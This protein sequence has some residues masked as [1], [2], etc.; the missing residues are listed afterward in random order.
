M[1]PG[2]YDMKNLPGRDMM[3]KISVT[4][5]TIL[6]L[7]FFWASKAPAITGDSEAAFGLDGSLRTVGALFL[8]YDFPASYGDEGMDD[9]FQALIRITAA[10]RP[11]DEFSY[12]VH[13]VQALTYFSGLGR[14]R[15]TGTINLGGGKTRYRAVDEASEWW[16]RDDV[17]ALLWVDRLNVKLALRHMDLTLGRQAV[18]FGKA[19]FWNPL[20]VYLPFDPNQFDRDYKAGVDAVRAD[21]PLGG[22]SGITLVGV[23]GRET[24]DSG[25]YLDGERTFDASWYGS[26]VLG[27]FFTNMG[28]FDLALQGGKIY[29]GYQIGAGVVG[30]VKG[31]EVRA[32]AA[33]F[34]SRGS[35]VLPPP[36]EGE[37]FED[38]LMVV[39]G[40][41][42]RFE[43][44]LIMEVEYL[45][46]GGGESNELNTAA[47]RLD[48]GCIR[49][50]GRH[51]AGFLASY[52][53]TPLVIGRFTALYSFS[54]GS[55]AVQPTVTLS[56]SNNSELLAGTGLNFGRRPGTNPT[57]STNV[58]SEFGSRPH[59]F[60][61]EFKVYF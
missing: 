61:A 46:N 58:R 37:L 19:H 54:D 40:L 42:R 49:H 24:D 38:H 13:M 51:L 52:E 6:F 3:K 2:V 15:G 47:L 16:T 7:L 17:S 43:S 23:L 57:G 30:E 59:F 10:G 27:R 11:R 44:S 9:Y 29:G 36:L 8:N 5:F 50:L 28:G 34:K 56:V 55:V 20:D 12:E 18:T 26:S 41:G 1:W 21:I 53:L 32:E 48:R 4:S 60:F 45:Y 35:P 33:Y 14:G 31:V 22:F 25:K 39:A